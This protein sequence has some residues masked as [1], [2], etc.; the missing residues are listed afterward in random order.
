MRGTYKSQYLNT[1]RLLIFKNNVI[2]RRKWIFHLSLALFSLVGIKG[3]VDAISTMDS[4]LHWVVA[5][6]FKKM[7]IQAKK[8]IIFLLLRQWSTKKGSI[9]PWRLIIIWIIVQTPRL[10]PLFVDV[11]SLRFWEFRFSDAEISWIWRRCFVSVASMYEGRLA[12]SIS[13]D[14]TAW[15]DWNI[16]LS[17]QKQSSHPR[18]DPCPQ[19]RLPLNS[20][21]YRSN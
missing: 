8:K 19:R 1:I 3:I 14:Q 20:S 4:A 16:H 12:T 7:S 17:F 2:A 18:H 10:S 13:P 6:T 5:K 11:A 9:L 21:E 15:A